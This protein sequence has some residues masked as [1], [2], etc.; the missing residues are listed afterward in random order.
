MDRKYQIFVS[1]TYEDLRAE[2]NE[3]I[4]ACLG[5]GHIPDRHGN[6]QRPCTVMFLPR[7]EIEAAAAG[8]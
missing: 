3:P 7:R 4:E 6:V 8:L 1:S 2:R 5:M